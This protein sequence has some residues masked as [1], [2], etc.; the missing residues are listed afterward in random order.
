[1][2]KKNPWKCH[3]KET[4][5]SGMASKTSAG[6]AVLFWGLTVCV[7]ICHIWHIISTHDQ[8]KGCIRIWLWNTEESGGSRLDAHPPPRLPTNAVP[9]SSYCHEPDFNQTNSTYGQGLFSTCLLLIWTNS[10]RVD[11]L[12]EIND[13]NL[14]KGHRVCK[15]KTPPEFSKEERNS[16]GS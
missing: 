9:S 3:I 7:L 2:E 8:R 1:M 16:D 12:L 6:P 10:K 4:L 11:T 15:L 5:K 13:K 14:F